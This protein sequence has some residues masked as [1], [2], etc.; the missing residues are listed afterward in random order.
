MKKRVLI[1]PI[2][3]LFLLV[4]ISGVLAICEISVSLINQDPYPATPGDYV[5]LVFQVDGVG[6]PECGRVQFGLLEQYPLIFDP[7]TKRTI[8][9]DAGTYQKDFSSFLMAPY[10]VR[11]DSDALNGDNPIEVEYRYGSNINYETKKFNLKIEDTRADFEIHIKDYNP[12]TK[13]LTFE[14]LNTEKVDVEALTLEIPTQD[15]I[16]IKGSKINIVG[17]L[18]SNEYTT[19]NFEATPSKGEIV[20]KIIYTDS[21]NK[22]RTLEKIVKF[23]P[24]YFEG[25]ANSQ[26][27]K[28][29]TAGILFWILLTINIF[30]YF[31]KKN[32][33][34][35]AKKNKLKN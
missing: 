32:K 17:D 11:V 24:E 16:I 14:I 15:N 5:E 9:I 1:L 20:V 13:L 12:T 27:N 31:Y 34:R 10:K 26:K 22:R 28:I 33:K 21:I 25:R 35:K 18:D 23:E 19:A 2:L 4:N 6:N 30:Y 7:T 3:A 29:G 8:T